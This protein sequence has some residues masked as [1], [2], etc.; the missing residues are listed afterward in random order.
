MLAQV[1]SFVLQGIDPVACEVE[2]DIA[3]KG[4]PKTTI[5]GLPD[6]AVKESIERVRSAIINSGFPFPMS[7]LL[8]N[9]APA[10]IRK[11]GPIFDL[12]IAIGLLLAT[13][14]IQTQTHKK[15]LFAGELALDGRLRP[16]NGVINL[17]LLAKSLKFDG[18]VV[19]VDNASEAAAV[20][21]INVYPADSLTSVI[22]FLN[23]T[24][25]LDAHSEI[26]IESL[27]I[28]E[29]ASTNFSDIKG[30]EAAKRAMLLAAAGAHNILM[31]GPA[32]SGK[33]MMARALAG[34]LPPLSR[35]EALD[36]T[37]IYSSVGLVPKGQPILT[38]R[39]I[40]SPH[41][42]ASSVAMI[43][44]G[45]IPR[46]GEVSLAHHGVLF[47]DETPEFPRAVLETLRQPLEDGHVTIAR[48]HSSITF[49]SRFML[50]AAMN[51]TPKGDKPTDAVSQREM[52]RYLSK[53]SGPLIDRIDIH[54][55][56]PPVPFTQLANEHS[57]TDS[58]TMR[59]SILQARKIQIKRNGSSLKPNSTLAGRE[60]NKY[61]KMDGPTTELVR[62]A[63]TE[64]NLS[65]RAYDKIR[66]IARTIADVEGV[67]SISIQHV[68]EAIQYRLLDRTR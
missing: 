30:Q 66:R 15:L 58:A 31:I 52:D 57:G 51:P 8:V 63:M 43:G 7:R 14:V 5:V 27:L 38:R 6:T 53:I 60:L 49:P 36:V 17:A 50:V 61:A 1:H 21:D 24:H 45:S 37:R 33:T 41:H 47:L 48:S 23:K 28:E 46:P 67:E 11:E 19:P 16:I 62:Q 54:V 18:V 42:T 35:D 55:E 12:P 44:G 13:N 68:A 39:P 59:K 56:V 34:I 29:Y 25:Q 2:V 4:L 65:A 40:R 64:L 3:D 10:D 32:G 22:G 20:G 9:L 26:D